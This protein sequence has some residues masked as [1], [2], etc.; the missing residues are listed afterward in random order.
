MVYTKLLDVQHHKLCV[1][2]LITTHITIIRITLSDQDIQ[3]YL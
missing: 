1:S 3:S 2:L